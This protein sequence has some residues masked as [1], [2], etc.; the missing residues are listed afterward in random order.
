MSNHF[1]L[2]V[3]PMS[4][5]PF[6]VLIFEQ[7]PRCAHPAAAFRRRGRAGDNDPVGWGWD[8]QFRGTHK[9]RL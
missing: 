6:K 5:R 8:P 1:N 4:E 2:G 9:F 3:A 7:G